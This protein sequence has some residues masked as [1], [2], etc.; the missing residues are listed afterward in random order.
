MQIL[1]SK[2][3]R[4]FFVHRLQDQEIIYVTYIENGLPV[5]VMLTM[6]TLQH[7]NSQGILDAIMSGLHQAGLSEDDLKAKLVGFGCDGASVMIGHRNGV[8]ARLK[9]M[10][11]SLVTIWCVAHRLELTALDSMKSFPALT[12]LKKSINGIYKHYHTSAKATRELKTVAEGLNIH[13]VKPGTIDGT[14]WLLHTLHGL[15]ALIRNYQAILFHLESH[16]SDMHDREASD[17]MKGRASHTVKGLKQFKTVIF[18]H[19]LLDILSE[20]KDLSLLFQRDGLTLQM[21]S[22]GLQKTTLALVAMKTVPGQHLKQF[23]DE[24]GPFPGNMYSGVQLDRKQ[25][26]DDNLHKVKEKLIN[27]FCDYVN[28]R[29]GSLDDGVFKAAATMFDLSNWPEDITDLAT[30]GL[31]DLE[32]FV[33][34]F[35][36]ILEACEDFISIQEA[37][38]EWIDL[39]VLVHRHFRHLQSQVLWQRLLQGAIGRPEQ[40][41]HMQMIVE[42]LLVF[43]MSTSCCERG[44]SCMKRIK[45]DWR[46]SL[47]NQM[48]NSL[49]RISLHGPEVEDYNAEQA[50]EKWWQSGQRTRRPMFSD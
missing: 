9:E 38:R 34:H 31:A 18:V 24:V 3:Q 32:T 1:P 26:D 30:F 41:P 10:F 25:V 33:S 43:P 16:A 15:S 39:K 35:K 2:G 4:Q 11:G 12:E 5:N 13:L 40:F 14:R 48:L 19:L 8:S 47:S 42:I 29:F 7:A 28:T 37:K 45:S 23:L 50:V 27:G 20:L 36:G 49:L 17:L 21:V 46:G 6:V 44:F 22:D